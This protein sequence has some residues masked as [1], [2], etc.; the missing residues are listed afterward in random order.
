MPLNSYPHSRHARPPPGAHLDALPGIQ[1]GPHIEVEAGARAS[2]AIGPPRV[3]VNHVVDARAA[4][5]DDP[6]VAVKGRGEAEDGV[7]AR[8]G[9]HAVVFVGKGL[10]LRAATTVF[11][12]QYPCP[13]SD[14]EVVEGRD[15]L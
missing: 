7:D 15:A 5:V 6:V 3:K 4:P 1:L 2:L 11:D 12:C 13:Y 10:K 9:R 14:V 8:G